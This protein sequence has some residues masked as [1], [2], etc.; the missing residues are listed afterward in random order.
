MAGKLEVCDSPYDAVGILGMHMRVGGME[1][2]A[3]S[4]ARSGQHDAE[5]AG[6]AGRLLDRHTEIVVK[7]DRH[8]TAQAVEIGRGDGVAGGPADFDVEGMMRRVPRRTIVADVEDERRQVGAAVEPQSSRTAILR[9]GH[10]IR[11][12]KSPVTGRPLHRPI[13]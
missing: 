6:C 2:R 4:V 11:Q 10:R 5:R 3:G 12:L 8:R 13:M 7:H 1:V 9:Q